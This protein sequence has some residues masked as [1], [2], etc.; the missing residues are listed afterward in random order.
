VPKATK[1]ERQRQN[2]EA[3][4]AAML[5]E[6]KRRKRLRTFRNVGLLL[7]PLVIIFVI[8]QLTN[9]DDS[10][11]KS[12]SRSYSKAPAQT[13]DPTVTYTAT[14]DTSEGTIVVNL[15]AAQYPKSVNNFVFLAKHKFYNGLLV[16]RVAQD[17]VFQTG[18]PDNT[19]SG[20]PGY[21]VVGEVPTSTPAYPV[22]AVAFAKNGTAP[23][24]TAGSQFFVVTGSA[25][26]ELPAD[27]AGIG[28]VTQGL[29]VAQKIAGLYP[30]G[31]D[32]EPTTKVTLKKITITETPAATTTTAAT[33]T[34][35]P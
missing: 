30:A 1:R 18:S 19:Q 33:T 7:I 2:K 13:I 6:E 34:S 9:S 15:D 23:A 3:R 14:I 31:G 8:L 26:L 4:R 27:Y 12:S 35:T 17:F 5:E 10:S 22:G 20:G 11:S 16:N 28:T 24:G 21:T 32:G 25:H 29:D